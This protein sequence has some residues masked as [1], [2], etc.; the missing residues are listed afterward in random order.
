MV[1]RASKETK[2]FLSLLESDAHCLDDIFPF[3]VLLILGTPSKNEYYTPLFLI[4]DRDDRP[5]YRIN[6]RH[7]D[8]GI[9]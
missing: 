6:W 8:L 4:Q 9:T 2:D 5:E 1:E 3:V 7:R